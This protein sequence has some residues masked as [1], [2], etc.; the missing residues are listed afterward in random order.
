MQPIPRPKNAAMRSRFVKQEMALTSAGTRRMKVSSRRRI[1]A[2]M[3]AMGQ[4][5][6]AAEP[7]SGGEAAAS[8]G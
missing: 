4:A 3:G 6:G 8:R 7:G 2:E 5:L 1:D